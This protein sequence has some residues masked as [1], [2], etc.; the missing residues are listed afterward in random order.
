MGWDSQN[1]G[2]DGPGQPKSGTGRGKKQDKAN[3]FLLFEGIFEHNSISW[4]IYNTQRGFG[5]QEAEW[6][7]HTSMPLTLS[8][9]KQAKKNLVPLQQGHCSHP[10]K[11]KT[12]LIR[13]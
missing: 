7:L 10:K 8:R 12:I 2:R 1:L 11:L 3:S 4:T 13:T 5:W 9:C 6:D